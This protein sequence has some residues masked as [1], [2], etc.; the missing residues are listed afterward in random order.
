VIVSL[1]IKSN[2]N[3]NHSGMNSKRLELF[4]TLSLPCLLKKF[5]SPSTTAFSSPRPL[6]DLYSSDSINVKISYA[7]IVS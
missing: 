1:N 2:A 5:F 3:V 4:S 7:L 6:S